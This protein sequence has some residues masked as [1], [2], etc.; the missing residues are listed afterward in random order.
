MKRKFDTIITSEDNMNLGGIDFVADVMNHI[1]RSNEKKIF[2]ELDVTDPDLS[3]DIK[4]K[5]FRLRGYPHHGRSFCT[6]I[7]PRL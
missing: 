4:D 3:A 5:M 7:Y 6:E 2:D 1:D